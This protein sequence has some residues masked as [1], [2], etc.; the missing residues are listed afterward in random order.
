M[1]NLASKTRCC[2]GVSLTSSNIPT[3]ILVTTNNQERGSLYPLPNQSN[4]SESPP[5]WA[6]IQSERALR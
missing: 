2:T 6:I 4:P 1:A 5:S 3:P